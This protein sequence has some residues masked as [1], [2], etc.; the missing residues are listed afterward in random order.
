MCLIN[1]PEEVKK[2]KSKHKN[3]KTVTVYKRMINN[4]TN[5]DSMTVTGYRQVTG[6]FPCYRKSYEY[7]VGWNNSNSQ[8]KTSS[9]KREQINNGMHTYIS[10]AVAKDCLDEYNGEILVKFTANVK[11]VLGVDDSGVAVF[12]KLHLTEGEYKRAIK[13]K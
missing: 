3:H 5:Y 12:K 8:R 2:F 9:L 7:K 1:D 13:V 11:D 6:L 4:K 10:L